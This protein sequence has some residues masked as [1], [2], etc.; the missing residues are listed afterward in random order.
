MGN[1]KCEGYNRKDLS[2]EQLLAWQRYCEETDREQKTEFFLKGK[3]P[4][5][6]RG[7][8]RKM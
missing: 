6:R 1:R 7:A 2:R 4:I 8:G 3:K 5:L